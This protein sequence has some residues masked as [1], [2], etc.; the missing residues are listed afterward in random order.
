MGQQNAIEAVSNHDIF[1]H[2]LAKKSHLVA[3]LTLNENLGFPSEEQ[4]ELEEYQEGAYLEDNQTDSSAEVDSDE[5]PSKEIQLFWEENPPP[6]DSDNDDDPDNNDDY[7]NEL[8]EGNLDVL[9]RQTLK[10]AFLEAKLTQVKCNIMLK[11][12]RQNPFGVVNLPKNARTVLGTPTF[13][14][15]RI[16]QNTAGRE[17]LHMGFKY[18][19]LKKL[20]NIALHMLPEFL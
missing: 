13:V 7:F 9:A 18:G 10:H 11:A 1:A 14:A 15:S 12:L 3:E 17:Y 5:E 19:I 6:N 2:E 20:Q 16:I 8:L 4:Y